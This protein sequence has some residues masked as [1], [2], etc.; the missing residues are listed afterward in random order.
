MSDKTIVALYDTEAEAETAV[1][2]FEQASTVDH[3]LGATGIGDAAGRMR[4]VDR[5]PV[6]GTP[7]AGRTDVV[8]RA[9]TVSDTVRRTE[10]EVED[11]RTKA[12]TTPKDRTPTPT[13]R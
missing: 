1:T 2:A 13:R 7:A 9:E 10:V 3:P 12:T 4:D 8:E 11:A 5:E 6:A